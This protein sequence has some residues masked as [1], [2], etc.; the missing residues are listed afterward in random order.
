MSRL[1]QRMHEAKNQLSS[2]DFDRL[3]NEAIADLFE[4]P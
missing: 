1:S 3:S 4:G 2:K